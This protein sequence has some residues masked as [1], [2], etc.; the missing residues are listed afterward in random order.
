M[1]NEF[2]DRRLKYVDLPKVF[3]QKANDINITSKQHLRICEKLAGHLSRQKPKT[4]QEFERVEYLKDFVMKTVAMNESTIGLLDYLKAEIEEISVDAKT[5]IEGA[6]MLDV[7][8][9]QSEALQAVQELRDKA[10]ISIYELRKDQ[11][12]ANKANP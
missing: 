3:H 9:D 10:V 8:K 12:R 11:L 7:I 2:K 1:D 5:L 6:K 4:P